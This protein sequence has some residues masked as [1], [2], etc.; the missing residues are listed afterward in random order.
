MLNRPILPSIHQYG[1]ATPSQQ[2]LAPYKQQVTTWLSRHLDRSSESRLPDQFTYEQAAALLPPISG[3]TGPL[4]GRIRRLLERDV[5]VLNADRQVSQDELALYFYRV[6]Q[7]ANTSDPLNSSH[8]LLA[9]ALS[10]KQY[11]AETA[12]QVKLNKQCQRSLLE[13][14]SAN[15]LTA[16]A[17]QLKDC[18]DLARQRVDTLAAA[19]KTILCTQNFDDIITRFQQLAPGSNQLRTFQARILSLFAQSGNMPVALSQAEAPPAIPSISLLQYSAAP[20]PLGNGVT[21][22]RLDTTQLTAKL[23]KGVNGRLKAFTTKTETL[24]HFEIKAP[25]S[26]RIPPETLS[27]GAT[28]A[29]RETLQSLDAIEARLIHSLNS[30]I[31]ALRQLAD[32]LPELLQDG[33][34]LEQCLRPIYA[35]IHSTLGLPG[36]PLWVAEGI[37]DEQEQLQN[38]LGLFNLSSDP[39]TV[40]LSQERFLHALNE[41]P[42]KL[43]ASQVKRYLT[44]EL[45]DTLLEELLHAHQAHQAEKALSQSQTEEPLDYPATRLL[46]YVDA[47]SYSRIPMHAYRS[48]AG[49]SQFYELQPTERDAKAI[50]AGVVKAIIPAVFAP[51]SQAE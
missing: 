50:K 21:R 30:Q 23:P 18:F 5:D 47:I 10:D 29:A 28:E 46:D 40:L 7:L 2:E 49:Q 38:V 8:F 17:R 32:G 35:A 45:L 42:A 9:R 41:L 26:Y 36:Y 44:Q 19:A 31:P 25:D 43:P 39:P 12:A 48:M 37:Y 14:L 20:A 24:A 33:E 51:P 22:Y 34:A 11:L 1:A 4:P 15:R 6:G 27:T 3:K 16:S 13:I